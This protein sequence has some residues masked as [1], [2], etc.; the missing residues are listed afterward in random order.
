MKRVIFYV[1]DIICVFFRYEEEDEYVNQYEKESL[2][3]LEK[4]E[5][6]EW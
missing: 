1:V 4:I 2:R 6:G 3:D 5:I